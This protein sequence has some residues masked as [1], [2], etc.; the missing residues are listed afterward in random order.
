MNWA[1][2]SLHTFTRQAYFLLGGARQQYLVRRD[3]VAFDHPVADEH[4]VVCLCNNGGNLHVKAIVMSCV[5][6]GLGAYGKVVMGVRARK[7]TETH[8]P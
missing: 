5:R 4:I 7:R 3:K 8:K 2:T 1:R 6:E